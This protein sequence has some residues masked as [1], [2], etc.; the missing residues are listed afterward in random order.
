MKG[1]IKYAINPP[2]NPNNQNI[3]TNKKSIH[4]LI[5]A[6]LIEIYIKCFIKSKLF[7]ISD[8]T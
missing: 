5:P 7:T 3:N 8:N 2:I 4:H 1:R 6:F